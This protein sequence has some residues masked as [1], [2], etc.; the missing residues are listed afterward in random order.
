MDK[1]ELSGC[2]IY[3]LENRGQLRQHLNQDFRGQRV[4]LPAIALVQ[5]KHARLV[6][7]YNPRRFDSRNR[8][9]EAY[10]P[11]ELA[12][13]RDGQNHRQ[14]RCLVERLRRYDQ[15]GAMTSLLAPFGGVERH[16]IDIAPLHI[17][18]RPTAGASTHSR[19][20]GGCGWEEAE[21]ASNSASV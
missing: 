8:H 15:D 14:F 9:G 1:A 18:S 21:A 13:G 16:Q 20:S 11:G 19:C 6:A 2:P 17:T 3:S 4:N 10:A 12:T 7:T 5:I